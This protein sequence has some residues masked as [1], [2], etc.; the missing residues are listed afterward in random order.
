MLLGTV[1]A[2]LHGAAMPLMMIVFGD[3][4]D[5][6][7]AQSKAGQ[8][9]DWLVANLTSNESITYPTFENLTTQ[10]I[11]DNFYEIM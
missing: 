8:A 10:I 7:I 3:V 4:T 5:L 11:I 6:F 9:L 1:C 2:C